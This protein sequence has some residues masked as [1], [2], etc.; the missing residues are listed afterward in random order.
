MAVDR[1]KGSNYRAQVRTEQPLFMR[2]TQRQ[3]EYQEKYGAVGNS[4][5]LRRENKFIVP[6]SLATSFPLPANLV[7]ASQ[8]KDAAGEAHHRAQAPVPHGAAKEHQ[9]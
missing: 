9:E 5:L 8:Q 2:K 7:A 1:V 3:K 4:E 6:A